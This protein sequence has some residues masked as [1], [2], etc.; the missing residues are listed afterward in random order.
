M[1]PLDTSAQYIKGV[2]PKKF[3][4]LNKLGIMTTRDVLFY[5]PRRHEDRSKFL[6]ISEI[7]SLV[8]QFHTIKGTIQSSS[9]FRTKTKLTIFQMAVSDSTGIVYATW[10]NQPYMKK[11]FK[12]GDN[13]ILYG[14]VQRY[15]RLQINVPEYELITNDDDQT[16]HTGR[17]VPIYPLV[18]NVRQRM[19]R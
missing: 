6:S 5:L 15:K 8:G 16:I 14:K 19:L 9:I 3:Q 18:E 4:L 1:D 17:I 2:G 7:K 11:Y 10:F 12:I 13:I